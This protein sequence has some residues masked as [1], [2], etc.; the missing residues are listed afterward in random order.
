METPAVIAIIMVF[1]LDFF[2]FGASIFVS[3]AH[4]LMLFQAIKLLGRKGRKDC[5]QILL[6]SFFQT[7]SS[8]TLSVGAWQAGVMLALVPIATAG[9]FW[10]QASREEALYPDFFVKG[11]AK[12]FRWVV[13]FM[14]AAAIPINLV[15]AAA[16][17]VVFP[18]LGFRT[19]V[20][21]G[22][23]K[24]G[25][26]E[27]V[28]LT[29][30]GRLHEDN[31]TVMW[32]EI[33]PPSDRPRWGGYLRGGALEAFDGKVWSRSGSLS[34]KALVAGSGGL[35]RA[36]GFTGDAIHGALRQHV[37]LINTAGSILFGSPAIIEVSAPFTTL[38]YYADGS[39][40]WTTG[41]RK[42]LAY[43]IVSQEASRSSS[44]RQPLGPKDLQANLDLPGLSFDKTK[45]LTRSMGGTGPARLRAQRIESFLRDNFT[46][47]KD[48]GSSTSANPIEEFL[49]VTK[50]GPCGHFSSAMAV[51]LR[52]SGI[53][54]RVV[55]GYYKGS[56][57]SRV[58]QYVIRE[59]DAHAWVEA[60]LPGQGWTAFDPTP[61][62]E[63]PVSAQPWL[64]RLQENWDYVNYTWDKLVIQY[65]LYSQ[66]RVLEDLQRGSNRMNEK[67]TAWINQ[68]QSLFRLSH[69]LESGLRAKKR[70][71]FFPLL[72]LLSIVGLLTAIALHFWRRRKA[73]DPSIAFYVQFLSRMAQ[74]GY[75]KAPYE[76]GLEY[77]ARLPDEAGGAQARQLTDRYYKARY[78]SIRA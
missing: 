13:L 12:S 37:T 46:Y 11:A 31:S 2:R 25:Y 22:M 75:P 16:L 38:Q 71:R 62:V 17:F 50:R 48:L 20:G 49:F 69:P 76:T 26:T 41:W 67:A 44:V 3:L 72:A 8:C 73:I 19:F 30:G 33:L 27:Q 34:Q 23:G 18:R 6:V 1:L 60:Y 39:F 43:D 51:M 47:A 9:L 36:P 4:F 57:N 68:L 7:L 32:L 29:L 53:P 28:N 35:I 10:L 15:L 70:L 64:V 63:G 59:K 78:R 54:A 14:S 66:V 77:A 58:G 65:D 61:R 21:V 5:A 52:L 40:R 24:S 56:W 55:S 45:I 42:P 74:K